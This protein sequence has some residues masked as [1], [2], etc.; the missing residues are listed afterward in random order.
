MALAA[1]ETRLETADPATFW[2]APRRRVIE[3]LGMDLPTLRARAHGSL[4]GRTVKIVYVDRQGTR[5]SLVDE[6]H[7]FLVNFLERLETESQTS[8]GKRVVS[9]IV[10]FET[11][12]ADDQVRTVLD[13]DV[14][15]L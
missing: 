6:D 5:R 14:S 15:V 13:A 4:D 7:R 9:R 10:Q 3:H 11:I 1:L 12:S 2:S 8:L